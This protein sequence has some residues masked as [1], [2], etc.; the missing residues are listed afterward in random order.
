M[1]EET[2]RLTD[3]LSSVPEFEGEFNPYA[4]YGQEEDVLKIYFKPDA[5]YAK[6]LNSRVTAYYSLE[7]N[8]LVGCAVKSVRSVLDELKWFDVEITDDKTRLKM[9]FFAQLGSLEKE[10]QRQTFREIGKH[11]ATWR[12][13]IPELA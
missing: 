6:R 7:D 12:D 2:T 10:E 13:G 8:S 3:F 1:A 4:Y 11:L 5:D 9:V